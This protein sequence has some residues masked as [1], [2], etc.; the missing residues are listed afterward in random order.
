MEALLLSSPWSCSIMPPTPERFPRSRVPTGCA[1]T[2]F[3]RAACRTSQVERPLDNPPAVALLD[4]T[5]VA[6]YL[7]YYS[8]LPDNAFR[9]I[10]RFILGCW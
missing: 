7:A 10:L 2:H 6:T 8:G 1:A 9:F 4:L 5:W 3:K